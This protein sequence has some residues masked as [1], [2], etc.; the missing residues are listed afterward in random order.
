MLNDYDTIGLGHIVPEEVVHLV[1]GL[2]DQLS[3]RGSPC[4]VTSRGFLL[5]LG[6]HHGTRVTR[7]HVFQLHTE[8]SIL[9]DD[10]SQDLLVPVFG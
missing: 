10:I 1:L 5:R 4:L 8:L 7:I 2:N 6:L 3:S 9:E